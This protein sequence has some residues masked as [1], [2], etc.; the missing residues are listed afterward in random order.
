MEKNSPSH[1]DVQLFR[2]GTWPGIQCQATEVT[3]NR[4][5][6]LLPATR[7]D[8]NIRKKI[9]FQW[10]LLFI[11]MLCLP[12]SLQ[13]SPCLCFFPLD[14]D[15]AGRTASTWLHWVWN[16]FPKN[17]PRHGE[18]AATAPPQPMP[19]NACSPLC[20][21]LATVLGY[22]FSMLVA[23]KD[24]WTSWYLVIIQDYEKEKKMYLIRELPWCP[25]TCKESALYQCL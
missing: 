1:Y 23:S 5:R 15:F 18:Q 21:I 6:S 10:G 24:I 8:D 9:L 12:D 4:S 11:G 7:S 14:T 25:Q 3:E 16:P 13:V 19:C 2:W 17:I 20:A 22:L